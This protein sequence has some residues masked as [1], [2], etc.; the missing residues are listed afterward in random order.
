M[1]PAYVFESERLG[2]RRWQPSDR[3]AFSVMNADFSVMKYFPQVLTKEASDLLID[4]FEVHFVE[5]GYGMWAVE[6]K[7]NREFIGFIGLLE[8][9]MDVDF[10]KAIEIGWRLDK[11]FWKKG[12]ASEGATACLEYAFNI[13]KMNEIYSFTAVL[14]QPSEKVMQRI[15]MEKIKE[16]DHPSVEIESPL[17]RHVLYKIQNGNHFDQRSHKN[18]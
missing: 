11:R 6:I 4:R 8:I 10:K 2:F 9:N 17:R 15:G 5:K 3:D 18:D 16:F 12:Y 1:S 7:E 14:N 13:L